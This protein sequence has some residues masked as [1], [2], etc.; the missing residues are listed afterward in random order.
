MSEHPILFSGEMVR[1]ILEGRKTQTRRVIQPQPIE[2]L[3]IKQSSAGLVVFDR[4]KMRCPYGMAGDCLWVRETFETDLRNLK[5]F[6][7]GEGVWYSADGNV[8]FAVGSQWKK[9]PAIH[10]PRWASRITLEIVKVRVER[11]HSITP[12][13]VLA[14]GCSAFEHEF[15][16]LWDSINAKRGYGW[17]ADPWVWVIEFKKVTQ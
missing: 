7:D 14:E 5:S 3:S 4:D 10:M 15:K 11:L 12:V 8:P 1:A 2:P 17:D 6:K 16:P 9:H 13:G